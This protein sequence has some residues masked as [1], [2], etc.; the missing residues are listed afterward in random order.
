MPK[1]SVVLPSYNHEKYVSECIQSI[2]DQTFQDFELIIT[3]DGSSDDTVQEIKKFTDKRIKLFIFDKNK[4]ASAAVNHCIRNSS[5]K[6][7]AMMNSDDV[8]VEDKLE[9]QVEFLDNHGDFGAVVSHLLPI[10]EDGNEF[11]DKNLFDH[12]HFEQENRGRYGWM[13]EA[14][15]GK[16]N[17]AHPSALIRRDCY[18][19]IG[20]YDERFAQVPDWDFWIRL[21][22]KYEV[23]I[24]PERLLKYRIRSKSQNISADK[25]EK[26]I[27]TAWEMIFMLDNFLNLDATE[28]KIVFPELE[29]VPIQDDIDVRYN[30]AL[31]ALNNDITISHKIFG[32][33]LLFRLAHDQASLE[34]LSSRYGFTVSDLIALSGREVALD[35]SLFF[36]KEQ[37]IQQNN[38]PLREKDLII[39]KN[40]ALLQ[41]KEDALYDLYHSRIIR[42][43][44]LLRDKL[45]VYMYHARTIKSKIEARLLRAA[46]KYLNEDIREIARQFLPKKYQVITKKV[47]N[48]KWDGPLISVVTPFYNH[49]KTINETVESVLNQTFQNFEYIIVND[50]STDTE[51][52]DVFESIN[53]P[54]I[55][56]ISQSNAGVSMARNKGIKGAKGK[57][58]LCLDSDDKIDATYLEKSLVVLESN[59][60][61][62]IVYSD[63][64]FFG[65]EERVYKEP[66]F[67]PRLLYKN[68][69]ITTAAIFRRSMWEKCGGYKS[70]IGFE[71][72]EFWMN[73]VESGAVARRIPEPLFLYRRAADSRYTED[74]KKKDEHIQKI[75]KL[76][77]NFHKSA[78]G[79]PIEKYIFSGHSQLINF[80]DEKE[81]LRGS[82]DRKNVLLIMPWLTF[83]GAETVVYNFCL[84]NKDIFNFSIITGH[85]SDN[86]WEY[87]FKEITSNIYHLPN[88][89][90]R[91]DEYLEFVLNY[92]RTRSIDIIHIVH[93]SF[94]YSS[95]PTVKEKFPDIK[96]VSTVFNTLAD[97]LRN[98]ISAGRLIDIHTTDNMKVRA[99]FLE[100]GIRKSSVCVI[101]NGID[102]YGR[103]DP[104]KYNRYREREKLDLKK[105]DLA[106]YFIGRLS[107]EKNPD[108]FVEAARKLIM[109]NDRMKFFVVGDGPMRV[110]I[111]KSIGSVGGNIKY[112]G[113]QEDISRFLST[114][115]VFVLPSKMEGFPLS[116][117]EAMAMGVCVVASNVGGVGDA[118]SEGVTGFLVPPNNSD[119]IAKKLELIIKNPEMRKEVSSNARKLVEEK[120]SVGMLAENYKKLYNDILC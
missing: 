25:P 4:G 48:A 27:R 80:F 74:K 115:D 110:S 57:Y 23:H 72:W 86:E 75:H 65:L 81:Y 103:F 19:G 21:C 34:I 33:S 39:E 76:H 70:G 73:A 8:F 42:P 91:E 96:I 26:R 77:P 49:G 55:I 114:A 31:L 79:V 78:R 52:N 44:I 71:D 119:E 92:I 99:A 2:L 116:N 66:E 17:F 88:L 112:L 107:P 100:E 14:F 7:I 43:V 111:E 35:P 37:I 53:H 6:Y 32:I 3:D 120:F 15:F 64:H 9:K 90:R 106:V 12:V 36:R 24:M 40:S 87:K 60:G 94:F 95:L 28:V 109:N 102:C 54:K 89:F 1:V 68:N 38:I 97:H 61:I 62:D 118:V 59:P 84:R 93:N 117:I 10:D 13:R 85:K 58:I 11:F 16:N 105:D 113:Y 108:V 63:M 50:G 69:I 47:S 22:Q 30:I 18:R 67:N 104:S 29:G 45:R 41:E 5:G 98:S 51:S 56:K 83:G 46:K 20:Y 82:L 101:Y